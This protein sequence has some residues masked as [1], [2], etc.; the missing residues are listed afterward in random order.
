MSF[1]ASPWHDAPLELSVLP[2]SRLSE[3]AKLMAD[4]FVDRPNVWRAH[5]FEEV[6]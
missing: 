5:W 6:P 3:A 4:A 2:A 1:P